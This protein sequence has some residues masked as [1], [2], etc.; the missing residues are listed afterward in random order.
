MNKYTRRLSIQFGEKKIER[1][2][3]PPPQMRPPTDNHGGLITF[4]DII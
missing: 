3:R 2:K 4:K 1:N